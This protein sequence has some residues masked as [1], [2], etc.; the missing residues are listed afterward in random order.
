[1]REAQTRLDEVKRAE[2]RLVEVETAVRA[3]DEQVRTA[4]AAWQQAHAAVKEANAAVEQAERELAEH[5]ARRGG[6]DDCQHLLNLMA[7]S[8]VLADS[9][10]QAQDAERRIAELEA[11]LTGPPPP[12]RAEIDQ[13]RQNRTEATQL[14]AK[15]EAAEIHVTLQSLRP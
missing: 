7:Q 9:L 11:S 6:L 2:Q 10:Q 1:L 5:Q 4:E 15:L 8:A 12:S 3:M 13:L 14:R